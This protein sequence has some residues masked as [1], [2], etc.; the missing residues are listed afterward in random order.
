MPARPERQVRELARIPLR[1]PNTA[2]HRARK[3]HKERAPARQPIPSP[4]KIR[5]PDFHNPQR[6]QSQIFQFQLPEA[7]ESFQFMK[8]IDAAI[9]L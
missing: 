9:L 6:K 7:N 1:D 5:Y 8:N 4:S 3:I 2:H